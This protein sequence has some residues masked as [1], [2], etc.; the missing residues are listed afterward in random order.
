MAAGTVTPAFQR[1]I[2]VYDSARRCAALAAYVKT[3]ANTWSYEV[4][5]EGTASNISPAT[6]L[7]KT[8]TMSF[9][10]DGTLKNA[11][12][13]A[14]P[15]VGSINVTIP[16][17]ASSGLS[18]QTVSVNMGTVD[19]SDGVTQY[20][21]PSALSSSSVDG[22]LFGSLAGV[23]IDGNG[24]VTAQFTNGLSQKVFK[25]PIA[26]FANPNGLSAVSGNAYAVSK[27]SGTPSLSEANTGGAGSIQSSALE[28]STVDLAGEFT[29]LITTQRA[30]SAS[31]RIV[32]TASQM[33]D[34][35]LQMR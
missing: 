6:N 27:D 21:S 5:Y 1:T 22:A 11:D 9:N 26:T 29:N 19:S 32:T 18:S 16:W 3:G 23:Q 17:A 14:S 2:N 13:T 15:A 24:Y 8:G 10:L 35:L 12:N 7:I 25:L 34:Q 20:E 31:A 28:S 33:L 4:S 30:Y